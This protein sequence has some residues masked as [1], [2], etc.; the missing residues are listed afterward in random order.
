MILV[1]PCILD[2]YRA[3]N[4]IFTGD[5]NKAINPNSINVTIGNYL[6]TYEPF[7]VVETDKGS[8]VY[9]V[10]DRG[11]TVLDCAKKNE[12]YKLEIPEEGLILAP[13]LFYLGFT[14]ECGGSSK[15]VPMY[16]GRSSLA[17]L[18]LISHFSAGFGDV[19][20]DKQWTLEIAT[21][22]PLKIYPGMEIGQI[23]F[24]KGS[25]DD[26]PE[27]MKYKGKYSAQKGVQSSK[28]YED[29]K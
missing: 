22:L 17:R 7:E 29:F 3:G 11:D 25:I 23:Y 18:G 24:V 15:F 4:I 20:F 16:E 1:K 28:L 6:E 8:R 5:I 27:E 21:K 12:T 13:E 2:E 19:G 26:M 9:P 14:V 10:L